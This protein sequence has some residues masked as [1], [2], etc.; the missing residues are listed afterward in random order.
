MPII[1]QTYIGCAV[2]PGIAIG[3][4][5]RVIPATGYC[6]PER[7]GIE[8]GAEE[9]EVERFRA[10]LALSV[11][12][13]EQLKTR[14]A[15]ELASSDTAIFDAHL[16]IA[17]D[18]MLTETVEQIIRGER[19]TAEYAVYAGCEKICAV[20]AGVDDKY[21]A[22]RI[23]DIKDVA[24]RIAGNLSDETDG[25]EGDED[26]RRIAVACTLSPS[27]TAG[28]EQRKVLGFVLEKGSAT[29]HASILA[30]SMRIPAVTGIPAEVIGAL[31]GSDRLI[32][33]GFTGRLIVN[34]DER[35]LETYRVKREELVSFYSKLSSERSLEPETPDGFRIHLAAN[36][37]SEEQLSEAVESGAS[38]VGLFRTEYLFLNRD[39]L[40]G[41]DEQFEVYRRLAGARENFPVV[42]RTLDVGGDKTGEKIYRTD[43]S[44]PFLGLR[45][46]R[47]CLHER[48]DLFET[49]LR[50]LLRAAVYGDLRVMIPMVISVREVIEVKSMIA[51]LREQ[52]IGEGYDTVARLPL[53]VMI[54]T[55]SAALMADRLAPLV[56]FFSIGTN[57]LVQYTLAIDRG[58]ARVSYLYRPSHPAVLELVGRTAA[59]ARSAR[60]LTCM[61]GQAAA[62]PRLVPLY[63]G[64]G[65]QELSMPVSAVALVRRVI[66]SVPMWEMEA[67]AG[68]AL[69]CSNAADTLAISDKLLNKYVPELAKLE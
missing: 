15:A 37:D 49:Q 34:P 10:A 64:L 17:G 9:R 57:D 26:D 47:L 5:K 65:V 51:R 27:D 66:R 53:G 50:A 16:L 36:I 59:A 44:N 1:N 56:D 38:G 25:G 22:E 20:F 48:Q 39:G 32:V 24:A 2:S 61:C 18:K 69:K 45:G 7:I 42:I 23:A 46:I 31:N 19:V 28:M 13:L 12:Q 54:E 4:A 63:V 55:P 43:E 35:A 52:L 41:E 14:L 30:R 67:A 62:E 11:Q 58:N 68:E 21:I 3:R 6:R 29:S 33:D 40:P 60:I 8:E